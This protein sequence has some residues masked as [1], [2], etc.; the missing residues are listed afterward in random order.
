MRVCR[1][2]AIALAFFALTSLP[3]TALASAPIDSASLSTLSP[4]PSNA[5]ELPASVRLME[6]E[7]VE[8]LL[9]PGAFHASADETIASAVATPGGVRVTGV[10]PG[11]TMLFVVTGE[12][13]RAVV[14]RVGRRMRERPKR[15]EK[16][17]ASGAMALD[18]R[19]RVSTGGIVQRGTFG[20]A[21]T[22]MGAMDTTEGRLELSGRAGD[23]RYSFQARTAGPL[24]ALGAP[25][26]ST[27]LT[28][29]NRLTIDA[30]AFQFRMG[31]MQTG[32]EFAPTLHGRGAE[33]VVR[34]GDWRVEGG[35]R[36][37]LNRREML[38][39][40]TAARLRLA[41]V[42]ED[43]FE[44]GAGTLF[45]LDGNGV[46]PFVGGAATLGG[47]SASV[48]A[49]FVGGSDDGFAGVFATRLAYSQGACGASL[50][51]VA[52]RGESDV[53]LAPF[54]SNSRDSVRVDARCPVG[55]W[56]FRAWGRADESLARGFMAGASVGRPRDVVPWGVRLFTMGLGE[57]QRHLV[58]ANAS[59]DLGDLR[60]RLDAQGT[61]A[62]PAPYFSE[63]LSA[64]WQPGAL[65]GWV[66][67][68]TI[69]GVDGIN[70][71]RALAGP[72][73]R[74]RRI[75][76]DLSVQ[77]ELQYAPAHA[78]RPF[79]VLS[80]QGSWTP[81][82]AW[83]FQV[84]ARMDPLQPERALLRAGIAWSFGDELP[85]EPLLKPLRSRMLRVR[86]FEDADGDGVRGLAEGPLG[87]VRVCIREKCELTGPDGVLEWR[88]LDEGD[89]DVILEPDSIAG[90][91]ATTSPVARVLV[92]GYRA[93][94]VS[95]GVRRLARL[96]VRAFLDLDDDGERDPNEPGLPGAR[97]LLVGA[98]G[99][100]EHVLN[101]M[102]ATIR[103]L[104]ALGTFD[105]SLDLLSLPVG[106]LPRDASPQTVS[107]ERWESREVLLPVRV[108]R[109]IAGRACIDEDGDGRCGPSEPPVARLQLG[110]SGRTTVTAKDGRF[111]LSPL[112]S[113]THR[114]EV[115]EAHLPDG[116][117]QV[118]SPAIELDAKPR[119]VD[120][121]SI[122]LRRAT[123][124]RPDAHAAEAKTATS[125]STVDAHSLAGDGRDEWGFVARLSPGDDRALRRVAGQLGRSGEFLVVRTTRARGMDE[126]IATA[127]ATEEAHAVIRW[128]VSRMGVP[129]R[130]IAL[131]VED[132][133]A[134]GVE[135]RVYRPN[136]SR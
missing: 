101:R 112:P 99:S 123:V 47:L 89:H 83:R 38:F 124:V 94:E 129:L 32:T 13:S 121:V 116:L 81:H 8:L 12:E 27:A 108:L 58:S 91:T 130:R 2:A 104:D 62:K 19:L 9:P 21:H 42:K 4:A 1:H 36:G 37:P 109:S 85:R 39:D 120:H 135:V 52:R 59:H 29:W 126:A 86:V 44:V 127:R 131:Q 88:G 34:A 97:I 41:Y 77:G 50:Q 45:A 115:E 54:L 35:L 72:M 17:H 118:T 107:F 103:S 48:N 125:F 132:G 102:G 26:G 96:E 111:L 11:S 46:M 33:A 80:A 30:P 93:A 51:W 40:P 15:E 106:H 70:A 79:A 92:G 73:W 20:V 114:V 61:F 49:G 16:R 74:D 67:L 128:I 133:D 6:A 82:P 113:G 23:A 25:G 3:S 95:F 14:V 78:D 24:G 100:E 7:S 60:L 117:A 31:Q 87:D 28:H 122:A 68:G 71:F 110:A 66:G 98:G 69:H 43:A 5:P 55:G 18:R 65:G 22:H 90:G 76:V 134:S 64:R 75:G 10:Q 136:A 84:V 53:S 63:L 105:V 57:R 119:H 56:L